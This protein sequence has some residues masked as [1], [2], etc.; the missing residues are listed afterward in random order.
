VGIQFV[1]VPEFQDLGTKVT[2]EI[3]AAI[4][5]RT[6][7]DQALENGQKLAEEVARNYQ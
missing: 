7:V 2:E 1:A 4:A 5:G 3:S 6:S